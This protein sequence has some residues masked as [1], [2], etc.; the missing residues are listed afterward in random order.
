MSL[1]SGIGV[2]GLSL[3]LPGPFCILMMADRSADVV[4]V[5]EQAA[6]ENG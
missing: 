3:P 1:L 2:L 4:K 5:D 6:R